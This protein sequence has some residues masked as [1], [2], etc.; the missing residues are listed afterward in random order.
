MVVD[1]M[2]H[3]VNVYP[4]NGKINRYYVGGEYMGAIIGFFIFVGI[5]SAIAVVE[6]I[7]EQIQ[8]RK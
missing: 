6:W 5:L 7:V 4:C 1:Y 3:H 8:N 2:V